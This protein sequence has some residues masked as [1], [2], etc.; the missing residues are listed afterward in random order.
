MKKIIALFLVLTALSCSSE[1]QVN[2]EVSAV[3]DSASVLDGKML[4][5]KN[6]ELFVKEYSDLAS[7]DS[8]ELKN[9]VSSK[10]LVSLLNTSDDSASI[11]G[12]VLSES[13]IIYSDA[14]KSVLNSESK[15]KINGNVL[16]LNERTFYL[17][18]K[19]QINKT[20][21][22][23]VA[24]KEKLEVYGS[25]LSVSS[26]VKNTTGRDVIPNENRIKTFVSGEEN[27]NVPGSRIRLVLDLYNETI[28]LNNVIQSSKMYLRS[29]LQYRS[30]S[31]WRCTWKEASNI[32][33]IDTYSLSGSNAVLWKFSLFQMTTSATQTSLIATW[34]PANLPSPTAPAAWYTNF[35]VSGPFK[36]YVG[37]GPWHEVQLSWY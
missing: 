34:N 4:S 20:P 22:Q 10:K 12:D 11:E 35:N 23:L 16:W 37:N 1:D 6:E 15:V 26:P 30:C 28:V 13:R 2:Q 25:L 3:G 8:D 19:N 21:E 32:R 5:F 27:F 14:L 24:E 33:V 17:L 7:L 29:T 18:S 36:I 31:T 9:W